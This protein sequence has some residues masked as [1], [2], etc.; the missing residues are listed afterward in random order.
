M[1]VE[2]ELIAIERRLWSNDADFYEATFL[3][4]AVLIFRETGRI[5]RAF[6]F[7]AIREENRNGRQWA[8]VAFD[9]VATRPLA[10]DVVL[11]TYEARA[12]WNDESE[13]GSALC[14]TIYVRRDDAWRVA[15]HQQ[16]PM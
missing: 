1:S 9:A 4:E 11:L 15:F 12:R 5:D 8:E 3:P 6:A 16:T 7:D 13:V 2:E 14:A 10:T